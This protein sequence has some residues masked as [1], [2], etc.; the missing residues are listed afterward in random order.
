MHTLISDMTEASS[1]SLYDGASYLFYVCF[2]ILRTRRK[3]LGKLKLNQK[4][5][6]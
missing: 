1:V 5:S 3:V 2:V 4:C 6:F